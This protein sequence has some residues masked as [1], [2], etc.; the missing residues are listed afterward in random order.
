[1][2]PPQ[3]AADSALL[4]RL[5]WRLM[6]LV[7][8]MYLVAVI[9]RQN[10]GFAKLQM[11]HAL[12]MS[13]TAYGLASSL[14][15]I[16]YLV[17]ELPSVMAVHRFGARM[18]FARIVLTW[19]LLT[20]FLGFVTSGSMFTA[21]R[22]LLGAAEA[23]LYPGLIYYLTLW[24]PKSYQVRAL[25]VLT[26]GSAF[27]NMLG[28]LLGGLFLDLNGAWG[29][30]GWQWVFVAT[31]VPALVV[32]ILTLRYLP[33]NPQTAAFLGPQER[34]QLSA[35]I[36]RERVPG[37]GHASIW[38][39]L[40]DPRTLL[41]SL[42]YMLILTALYGV[43]YWLPTVIKGFGVSGTTNGIL[44]AVP[45]G[46]A[47]VMLVIVPR[48]LRNQHDVLIGMALISLIGVV[49]F[50]VSV[51]AE[52][53]LLRF[54]ALAIGTPCVSLILPCFW[55]IPP[56]YFKGAQAAASLAAIS[57]F[58][59]I[60]GFLAQNVMPWVAKHVG[61]AGGAMYVPA[62]CL[63]VLAFGALRARFLSPATS[64]HA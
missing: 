23:G 61:G 30:A 3:S 9:D 58:G 5:F 14:F 26:L 51:S 17:F 8:L 32:T 6:P 43:I 50:L 24:F 52:N 38:G 20:I 29:L 57:S 36:E 11:V 46:I 45:W 34:A 7:T 56:R 4:K 16:G 28:S 15:F 54:A 35:A 33:D 1:M 49:C 39:V 42:A 2:P 64:A 63:V 37:V 40:V 18:W 10:V 60:G 59:N 31:G 53:V 25:G 41:F 48:R 62:A 12:G 21:L 19:G 22:F 13:E 47:A 44:N 55:S 27:G